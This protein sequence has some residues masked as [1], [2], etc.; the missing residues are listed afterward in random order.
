MAATRLG[1]VAGDPAG[2]FSRAERGRLRRGAARVGVR[3]GAT[4]RRRVGK[5]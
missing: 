2:G 4:R 5:P 3:D 1:G